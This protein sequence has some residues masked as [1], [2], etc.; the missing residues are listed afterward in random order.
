M[1]IKH[2]SKLI[3][4]VAGVTAGMIALSAPAASANIDDV[5]NELGGRVIS[6]HDE[7]IEEIG[8]NSSAGGPTQDVI[9]E[10]YVYV[11]APVEDYLPPVQAP[12]NTAPAQ[13]AQPAPVITAQGSTGAYTSPA[14]VAAVQSWIAAPSLAN[15]GA[16]V[17]AIAIA[18]VLA[19]LAGVIAVIVSHK[20]KSKTAD[21]SDPVTE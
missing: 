6:T 5:L 18:A 21:T 3:A 14:P 1:T 13:P 15:T 4:A 16:S 2:R 10:E 7:V 17:I 9:I 19:L 12:A 20:R 8:G 11:T